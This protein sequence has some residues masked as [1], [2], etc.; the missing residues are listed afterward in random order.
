MILAYV[1]MNKETGC[2]PHLIKYSLYCYLNETNKQTKSNKQTKQ[3]SLVVDNKLNLYL[4]SVLTNLNA[5]SSQPQIWRMAE[6][7]LKRTCILGQRWDKLSL[8]RVCFH[9]TDSVGIA[10]IRMDLL[11]RKREAASLLREI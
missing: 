6:G 1:T 8:R 5:L 10:A 11:H 2:L 4:P 7:K 3:A 9:C